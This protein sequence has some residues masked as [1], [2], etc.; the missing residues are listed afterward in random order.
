MIHKN[1]FFSLSSGS[2]QMS[3]PRGNDYFLIFLPYRESRR[4]PDPCLPRDRSKLLWLHPWR[5]GSEPL[6]LLQR[7]GYYSC[8]RFYPE[9]KPPQL[10][11]QFYWVKQMESNRPLFVLKHWILDVQSDYT[12]ITERRF[13]LNHSLNSLQ[14]VI[15][16]LPHGDRT[17]VVLLN[18]VFTEKRFAGRAVGVQP[19][20]CL[21]EGR[22][23][24]VGVT[25]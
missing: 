15:G 24:R 13:Y 18:Q 19:T 8:L 1:H 7:W 17:L 20:G 21:R 11:H 25:T 10:V 4:R 12:L 3:S 16:C 2:Y 14:V 22:I 9:K 6:R 23:F 5:L